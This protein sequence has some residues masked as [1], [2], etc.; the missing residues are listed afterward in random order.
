MRNKCVAEQ[1]VVS[2][3]SQ[4]GQVVANTLKSH[5]KV[6]PR[7][8]VAKVMPMTRRSLVS[9]ASSSEKAH[10]QRKNRQKRLNRD[11]FVT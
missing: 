11:P 1:I 6:W 5:L 2:A 8:I 4:L 3:E 9:S 10:N 7:R